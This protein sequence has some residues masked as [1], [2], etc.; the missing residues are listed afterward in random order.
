MPLD[1]L[2]FN[3]GNLTGETGGG[4]VQGCFEVEATGGSFSGGGGGGVGAG[5]GACSLATAKAVP[6]SLFKLSWIPLTLLST[7]PPSSAVAPPLLTVLAVDED[8]AGLIGLEPAEL[9]APSSGLLRLLERRGRSGE[10]EGEG[11]GERLVDAGESPL[12]SPPW[13]EMYGI[14]GGSVVSV[15]VSPPA[16]VDPRRTGGVGNRCIRREP[17]ER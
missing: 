14:A 3:S 11:E 5:V 8:H 7:S 12:P 17:G 6:S 1:F 2:G 16:G 4:A 15:V 9:T 13:K 10:V